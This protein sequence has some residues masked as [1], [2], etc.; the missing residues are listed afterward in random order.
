MINENM[1]ND[2]LRN[3]II[4]ISWG[5]KR[6]D[7][8]GYDVFWVLGD[9]R[10]PRIVVTSRHYVLRVSF[11]SLLRLSFLPSRVSIAISL[12]LF[13]SFSFSFS[14]SLSLSF[15]HMYKVVVHEIAVDSRRWKIGRLADWKMSRLEKKRKEKERKFVAVVFN[16]IT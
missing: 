7:D 16:A 11:Q 15:S 14:F 13:L 4:C 8:A 6:P 5:D 12:S 10:N 2:T 9:M 3:S 1:E